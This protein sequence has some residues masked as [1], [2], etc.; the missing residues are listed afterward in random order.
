MEDA[1]RG[2]YHNCIKG[3]LFEGFSQHEAET[4]CAKWLTDTDGEKNKNDIN[5]NFVD[6]KECVSRKI[7]I[8]SKE[9]PEWK[10]EKVVA[11]AHGY[12]GKKSLKDD[13][14]LSNIIKRSTSLSLSRFSTLIRN[15]KTKIALKVPHMGMLPQKTSLPL[16]NLNRLQTKM[17]K[18]ITSEQSWL[19]SE[20]EVQRKAYAKYMRKQDADLPDMTTEEITDSIEILHDE[21]LNYYPFLSAEEAIDRAFEL[22]QGD[23]AW[24]LSNESEIVSMNDGLN[25]V[26]KA[27][28]ILAR[29]M[30][31]P[32]DIEDDETGEVR[33]EYHFK[34]Y[35]ELK[36]A[37]NDIKQIG[38]LDIIIEHQDWYGEE[39]IIGH[40]KEFRADDSTRTIRGMGYFDINKLP[41]GI[42]TMIRDG[43]IVPVSIGFLAMLGASG[44]WNDTEYDHTQENIILR[45]L[46]IVVDAVARCPPDQCGVNLKDAENS[47]NIKTFIIINKDSYFYNICNIYN[48]SKKETNKEQ[49]INK[50]TEKIDMIQE[51]LS[52]GKLK[53][54]PEIFEAFLGKLRSMINDDGWE[55]ELKTNRIAQILAVLGIKGKSDS[56][57]DD[58]EFQD[59][60]TKK[61]SELE[62][63]RKELSDSR[64]RVKKFEEKERLNYIRQIKKF[65]DKYSDEELNAED[66]NSL[67]KI[68]DAVSRFA[69]STEKPTTIPVAPKDDKKGLEKELGDTKR[70]DFSNVFEDVNKEFNL[71]GI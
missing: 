2:K 20:A 65:G 19:T 26:I 58:K 45:H 55:Q 40:V 69:P 56:K 29:E 64:D 41:E 52:D 47:E 68:A 46:A 50:N 51:D 60:I 53:G 49:N 24:F 14:D 7:S 6:A 13:I 57:M 16:K 11:A 27:P 21:I 9:H 8:F 61:D 42:L 33:R 39:N 67:E 17:E 10:H 44:T 31:Q 43:T 70:I 1:K 54:E 23:N 22:P 18:Q 48:D 59:A 30:V 4:A 35:H 32:Y 3:R 62:E 28:I 38:S 15:I 37:I 66:L 34:P 12:C 63:I 5:V 36:K 25:N 71:E